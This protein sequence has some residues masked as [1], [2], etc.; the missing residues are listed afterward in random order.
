MGRKNGERQGRGKRGACTSRVQGTRFV[1]PKQ[2]TGR[3][4]GSCWGPRSPRAFH[5]GRQHVPRS[6]AG[7]GATHPPVSG[8]RVKPLRVFVFLPRQLVVTALLSG[9]LS[10]QPEAK[11]RSWKF[12]L[13]VIIRWGKL[14][15]P[16]LFFPTPVFCRSYR[17]TAAGPALTASAE[18]QRDSRRGC[19]H[20]MPHAGSRR[21][22]RP[23]C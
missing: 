3:V 14:R 21:R 1:K 16:P 12:L 9:M 8:A 17:N 11:K 13:I 23:S 4:G 7:N 19:G 5:R 6:L 20:W 10:A 18:A 2:L 22:R 15:R